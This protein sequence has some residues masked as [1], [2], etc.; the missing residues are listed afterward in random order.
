MKKPAEQ[1][2][3]SGAWAMLAFRWPNFSWQDRLRGI[4]ERSGVVMG[5]NIRYLRP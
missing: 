4:F 3:Q 5:E 2:N 1:I